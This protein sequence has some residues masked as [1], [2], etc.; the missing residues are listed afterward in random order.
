MFQLDIALDIYMIQDEVNYEASITRSRKSVD[1]SVSWLDEALALQPHTN[2]GII[3]S[4]VADTLELPRNPS[5]FAVLQ[6]STHLNSRK[7]INI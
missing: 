7:S 3:D 5:L 1:R 2:T 4:S 6:V